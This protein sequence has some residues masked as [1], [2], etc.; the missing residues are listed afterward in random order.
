MLFVVDSYFGDA[1]YNLTLIPLLMK[2]FM[3]GEF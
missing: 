2:E 1:A 3:Y